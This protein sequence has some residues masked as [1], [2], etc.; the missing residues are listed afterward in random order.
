MRIEVDLEKCI[1]EG[2]CVDLCD[3]GVLELK[4]GKC[5]VVNIEACTGCKGCEVACEYGALHVYEE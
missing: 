1:G 5:R 4:D 2:I 3:Y